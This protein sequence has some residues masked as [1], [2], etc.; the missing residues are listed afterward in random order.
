MADV[1]RARG[2]GGYELDVDR[3]P[4]PNVALSVVG[5]GR[6][7]RGERADDLRVGEEEVD[8]AGAG[9]LR[10]PHQAGGQVELGHELVSDGPRLLAKFLGE[11][12]REIGGDVP[13]RGITR[14]LEESA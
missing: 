7:N 10:F 4:M 3:R 1:Q 12:Q 9:D 14:L 6:E 13:V 8:E 5:T 2:I 11:D